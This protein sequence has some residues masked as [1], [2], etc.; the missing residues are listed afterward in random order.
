MKVDMK[1]SFFWTP[2]LAVT[3]LFVSK[4]FQKKIEKLFDACLENHDSPGNAATLY[5]SDMQYGS[6]FS[7]LRAFQH[8]GLLTILSNVGKIAKDC[9]NIGLLP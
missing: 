2:D 4:I 3:C 7:L 8:T 9:F 1:Y 6:P 5:R